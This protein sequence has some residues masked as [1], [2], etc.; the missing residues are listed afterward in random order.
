MQTCKRISRITK[1]PVLAS[2]TRVIKFFELLNFLAEN[3]LF[4]YIG[5]STFTF[6]QHH[7][8]VGFVAITLFACTLAR[9]I[10]VYG[11]SLIVNLVR[12]YQA[13]YGCVCCPLRTSTEPVSSEWITEAEVAEY[14]VATSATS[15]VSTSGNLPSEGLL[16]RFLVFTA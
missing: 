4:A 7:W 14:S 1:P 12:R 15:G 8:H 6:R 5:V 13:G 10:P 16:K 11:L 3:F 9:A 2:Q